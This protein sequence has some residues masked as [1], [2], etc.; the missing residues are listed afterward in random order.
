MECCIGVY[1]ETVLQVAHFYTVVKGEKIFKKLTFGL[2]Y[3]DEGLQSETS[4]F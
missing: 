1:I 3:S 2:I 4:A